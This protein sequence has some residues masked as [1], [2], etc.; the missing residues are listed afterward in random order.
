MKLIEK[1][2]SG[3]FS[4]PATY[5][6]KPGEPAGQL[7]NLKGDPSETNNLYNEKPEKVKELLA[8]L[9]DVRNR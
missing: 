3:G 8:E 9:N 6:P 5:D 7:Y 4:T 2:G 1:R